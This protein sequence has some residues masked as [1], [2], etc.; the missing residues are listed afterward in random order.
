[1]RTMHDAQV[2]YCR[3]EMAGSAAGVFLKV[4][5][6]LSCAADRAMHA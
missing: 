1:M 5:P 4:V 3:S 2:K 6:W